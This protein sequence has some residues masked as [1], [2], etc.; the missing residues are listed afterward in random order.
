MNAQALTRTY[1]GDELQMTVAQALQYLD[2]KVPR[3]FSLA[4]LSAL[5]KDCSR[6]ARIWGAPTGT[7]PVV[8]KRWPSEKS[9]TFDVLKEVFSRN[10][11]T[12]AY[13]P[14]EPT[15]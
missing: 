1:T 9:Y 12:K 7:V 14:K 13:M 11:S 8:G 10:P 3:E 2:G 15:L 4:E 6:V 5:G